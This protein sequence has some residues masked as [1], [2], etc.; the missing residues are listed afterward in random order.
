[1]CRSAAGQIRS[2]TNTLCGLLQLILE[3]EHSAYQFAFTVVP[4]WCVEHR[5]LPLYKAADLRLCNIT[6][7]QEWYT[8]LHGM[9]ARSVVLNTQKMAYLFICC[10][11]WVSDLQLGLI[12]GVYQNKV[13]P[14]RQDLQFCIAHTM[15]WFLCLDQDG[16]ESH[17]AEH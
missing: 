16:V 10:R 15:Y 6:K 13:Q 8:T 1:M 9:P 17:S 7:H 12:V 4:T 11:M 2:S 3:D 14:I 5:P